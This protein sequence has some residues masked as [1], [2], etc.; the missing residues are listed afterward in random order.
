MT[1]VHETTLTFA[2]SAPQAIKTSCT[3]GYR[4]TAEKE[5]EARKALAKHTAEARKGAK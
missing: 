2:K 5:R 1:G 4:G 3:C